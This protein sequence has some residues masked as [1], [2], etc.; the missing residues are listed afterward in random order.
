VAINFIALATFGF[1][2]T[3]SGTTPSK[4]SITA[5][6]GADGQVTLTIDASGVTDE[7]F[8]RY[9]TGTATWSAESDTWKRIGDGDVIVT[10]LTNGTR[11]YFGIY[12]KDTNLTSDWDFGSATPVSAI[13]TPTDLD[14]ELIPE[15]LSIINEYGKT[16][17]FETWTSKVYDPTTGSITKDGAT[18][19][20]HKVS[21]PEGYETKYIDGN[22]IQVGDRKIYL[23]ASGLEFTPKAGIQVLIDDVKWKIKKVDEIFTGEQKGLFEIQVR[24]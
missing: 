10:G 13:I 22:L 11:Y 5:I 1:L 3:L 21:P 6:E 14:T 12:T 23:P 9:R 19:H 17:I 8:V 16:V 4:P 7:V 15:I 2:E 24:C 20:S 18:D